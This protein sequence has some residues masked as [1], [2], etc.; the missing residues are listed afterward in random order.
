[1]TIDSH[2][3]TCKSSVKRSIT[4]CQSCIIFKLT[5]LTSKTLNNQ[6]PKDFCGFKSTKISTRLFRS[7]KSIVLY[8]IKANTVTYDQCSFCHAAPELWNLLPLHV[9]DATSNCS[10]SK[11]CLNHTSSANYSVY[12]LLILILGTLACS[13]CTV[14]CGPVI[15]YA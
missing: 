13:L 11:A 1:M 3:R 2:A 5:L 4:G 15:A 12:R 10:N 14:H 7:S 6:V 9:K 8:Y